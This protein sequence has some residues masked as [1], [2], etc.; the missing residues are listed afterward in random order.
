[1]KRILFGGLFAAILASAA[2]AGQTPLLSSSP[3]YSEASQIIPAINAALGNVNTYAQQELAGLP[4]ALTTS[5]TSANTVLATTISPGQLPVGAAVRIKGWGV[6]SADAN[7]KTITVNFGTSAPTVVVT[8][9]GNT[10]QFE[11]VIQNVGTAGSPSQNIGC[12]GSTST[13]LIA[14]TNTNSTQAL[15]AALALNVTGTAATAGT[16][17][18]NGLTVELVR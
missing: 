18:F 9:S 10:W 13:T 5:G 6:N 11:C 12:S 8:G 3:N 16:M 17:T 2:I 4:A 7:A 14:L 1:M 15:T